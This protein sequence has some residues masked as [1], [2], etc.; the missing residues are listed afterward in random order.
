MKIKIDDGTVVWFTTLILKVKPQ[1]AIEVGV[2]KREVFQ[3]IC[4]N[5][6]NE[7]E[8]YN[9]AMLEAQTKFHIILVEAKAM[10]MLTPKIFKP[11]KK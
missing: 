2:E 3:T 10:A 7:L 5:S 1:G 6:K 9:E 4:Q 8:A 11:K